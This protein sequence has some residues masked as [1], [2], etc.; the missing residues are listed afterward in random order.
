ML[1]VRSYIMIIWKHLQVEDEARGYQDEKTLEGAEPTGV[2]DKNQ[3]KKK[4]PD[5]SQGEP[6]RAGLLGA[7]ARRLTRVAAS[8][9]GRRRSP[10]V[11]S[12]LQELLFLGEAKW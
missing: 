8:H 7:D 11:V 10:A 12:G 3:S 2:E 9:R 4:P 5:A 1:E 6:R